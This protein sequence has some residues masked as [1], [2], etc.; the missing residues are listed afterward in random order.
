MTSTRANGTSSHLPYAVSNIHAGRAQITA[1]RRRC[2]WSSTGTQSGSQV[3]SS[4]ECHGT[5]V[6]ALICAA[7]V[8]FPD[9]VTPYTRNRSATPRC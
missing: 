8:D 4:T 5:P 7:N 6:A 3:K 2:S 9:P 1:I